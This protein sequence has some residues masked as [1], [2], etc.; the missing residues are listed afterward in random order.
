MRI[1]GRSRVGVVSGSVLAAFAFVALLA[2]SAG[3]AVPTAFPAA[4]T[5][6]LSSVAVR[7]APRFGAA[8][9]MTLYQHRVDGRPQI[10]LAIGKRTVGA[11]QAQIAS[12]TLRNAAAANALRLTARISGSSENRYRI[13]IRD[14]ATPGRD[15]F[16]LSDGDSPLFEPFEYTETSLSELAN[17]INAYSYPVRATVLAE[18]TPLAP[19]A[20][21]PLSGGQNGKDGTVWY[22]LNLPVRP[23]GQTGWVPAEAVNVRTIRRQVII[24]RRAHFLEVRSRGRRIFRAP[25][26]TGRADR[27]TPLGKFYVAAKYVPPRN[28]AVSTF[29]LELSAPAGL[30]DFLKGGVVGIHGTPLTH[31]VGH[32]ASN[33]CIRVHSSTVLRLRRIVPLGTPVKIVR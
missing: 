33:G 8:R 6:E 31:T 14:S 3:A 15:E 7:R 19:L 13:T 21:T 25:V 17:H 20:T 32:N 5:V 1:C 24:H 4:G 12:L 22:R 23:F 11:V 30:P 27:P 9:K 2:P 10:V 18:G 29:A 16:I 26:A 28:A